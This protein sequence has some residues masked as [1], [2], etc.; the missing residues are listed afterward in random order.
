MDKLATVREKYNNLNSLSLRERLAK[1]SPIEM[2]ILETMNYHGISHEG[3]DIKGWR[4]CRTRDDK[5]L[6]RD[7]E[8]LYKDQFVYAQLKFRQPNSG[9]DIGCAILQP[10]PGLKELRSIILEKKISFVQARDY[11][12]DGIVY[13][14]SIMPGTN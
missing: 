8:A 1:S 7:A 11:K 2:W 12:F 14:V 9:A 4:K 5:V 6:K 10:Y 13:V 3:T